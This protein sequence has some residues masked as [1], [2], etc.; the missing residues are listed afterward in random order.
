MREIPIRRLRNRRN[1]GN[2][3]G[4]VCLFL[5]RLAVLNRRTLSITSLAGRM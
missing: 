3:S 2:S 4:F 1:G 5:E